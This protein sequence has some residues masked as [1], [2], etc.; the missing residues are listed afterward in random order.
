MTKDLVGGVIAILLGLAFCA[1]A[2][3]HLD[4]GSF[5][6]LGPGMFPCIVGAALALLGAAQV[7]VARRQ[8]VTSGEPS[9]LAFGEFRLRSVVWVLASV[10][11]FGLSIRTLG[12][13]P[14]ILLTV[15]ISTRA[16][17]ET[18]LLTAL[19]LAAG[20]SLLC[21]LIFGA[22]LGLPIALLRFDF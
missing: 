14:A 19:V 7:L 3:A 6:R 9:D 11:A 5:R 8:P 1:Y 15:V 4:I 13:I 17:S 10:I 18:H 2:Y 20:L 12:L 21:W 16:D 22:A